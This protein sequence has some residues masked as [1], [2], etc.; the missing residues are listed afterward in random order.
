MQYTGSEVAAEVLSDFD[1]TVKRAFVKV[2]PHEY[3]RALR[4]LAAEKAQE[5]LLAKFEGTDALAE[6]KKATV[7]A[8]DYQKYAPPPPQGKE[9]DWAMLL[10]DAAD[11]WMVHKR[12][13][14]WDAGRAQRVDSEKGTQKARGFIEYERLALPYR[15]VPR[16]LTAPACLSSNFDM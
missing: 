4:Q 3:A 9:I 8:H 6:L 14:T 12:A 16:P 10:K 7:A 11:G 15:R 5:D 1:A 2:Y 13:P